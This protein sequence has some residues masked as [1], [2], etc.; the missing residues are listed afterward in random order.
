MMAIEG[1]SARSSLVEVALPGPLGN[2][3]I[4]TTSGGEPRRGVHAV[5]CRDPFGVALTLLFFLLSYLTNV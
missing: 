3:F 4:P 5:R 1:W 2:R